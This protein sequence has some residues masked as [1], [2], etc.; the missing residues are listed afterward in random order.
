MTS[1]RAASIVVAVVVATGIVRLKADATYNRGGYVD[2]VRYGD[3]GPSV[4]AS[5][6]SRTTWFGF[7]PTTRSGSGQTTQTASLV[8]TLSDR[9]TDREFWTLF[10]ELSEP[11]GAFKSDNLVSNELRFQ[12]VIPA[13]LRSVG[14]GGVYLGV[15]PEQNFTYLA[16]LKP[17]LAFI[18]DVRRANAD[19]HLMYKALFEVSADRADFVSRLF[20]RRRAAGIDARST[21]AEIFDAYSRVEPNDRLFLQNLAVVRNQLAT[22]H[23]FP[24]SADD[25][26]RIESIAHV[27]FLL[28]PKLQYSPFGSFGGTVQPTYAELMA[29]TDGAGAPRGFLASEAA[30]AA[31]KD[32][33]RRNLV[34][35]VV[36]NFAGPTALR[37]VGRYIRGRGATVSTFYVSNVEEYLQQD[38][39]WQD[40]CANVAALPLDETST[41][42]R[43]VRV[44]VP[45]PPG[46]GFATRLDNISA[47]L[48]R[49]VG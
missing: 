45:E 8:D 41:F 26:D 43:S 46:T 28:G 12:T 20:S 48:H 40:F 9:L 3:R 2:R 47:D 15:G 32:I 21:A 34:V 49:C 44:S 22:E 35:P 18:V 24:M 31:V 27:F 37:A 17:K 4:V 36:G 25:F 10:S 23:G 5:G 16:A 14:P 6:F 11:G 13:L 29:A 30:F 33:E 19:L 42:I 7:R 38:G 39:V 1:R